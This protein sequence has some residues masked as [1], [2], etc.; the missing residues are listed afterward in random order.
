MMILAAQG[1]HFTVREWDRLRQGGEAFLQ[2]VEMFGEKISRV[3]KAGMARYGQ[4]RAAPRLVD[5]E[6]NPARAWIAPHQDGRIQSGGFYVKSFGLA[7]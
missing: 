2:P 6:R 3:F 1:D 5:S 4:N 7:P